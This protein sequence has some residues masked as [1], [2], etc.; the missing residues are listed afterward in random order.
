MGPRPRPGPRARSRLEERKECAMGRSLA[1]VVVLGLLAG[2]VSAAERVA[3]PAERKVE[4]A[5]RLI[6]KDPAG[7]KGH[8]ALAMALARRARETSDAAFY[9]Q[10]DQAL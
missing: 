8:A 1:V 6:A 9:V 3:S 2:V 4:E 7:C 10:A 5:R